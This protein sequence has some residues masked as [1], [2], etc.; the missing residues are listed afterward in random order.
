MGGFCVI[1]F[2]PDIRPGANSRDATVPAPSGELLRSSLCSCPR[3]GFQ[4]VPKHNGKHREPPGW[5]RKYSQISQRLNQLALC[6]HP[7]VCCIH[8]LLDIPASPLNPSRTEPSRF[9]Q[10]CPI[11]TNPRQRTQRLSGTEFSFLPLFF[12]SGFSPEV[13]GTRAALKAASLAFLPLP[14]G[15]EPGQ[16]GRAPGGSGGPNTGTA[17]EEPAGS[18]RGLAPEGSLP[19]RAPHLPRARRCRPAPAL[20]GG[21]GPRPA[22]P[23]PDFTSRPGPRRSGPCEAR[24]RAA[25]PQRLRD[26]AQE[27]LRGARRAVPGGR[28]SFYSGHSSFGMYCMMFLALYVQARLVGK[29]ARLLRPTIQ[30]LLI[31][32]AIYVGYTRVSDYKHHWSDVLVGLLQGALIAVLIVHY[33]SDFFKQRPPRQCEEKDPERKPSLPLTLTDPDH[34]H[35]SYRG[36]P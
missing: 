6:A 34:N 9:V 26:G 17:T 35:Y 12:S 28:L 14:L 33:V 13:D 36:A 31:A 15:R 32:F 5:L 30:F 24:G 25:G 4:H 1:C 23:R 10:D 7:G 3:S 19:H 2:L 22:P 11:C 8:R 21:T 20:G 27:G 29:W 18:E 16:A